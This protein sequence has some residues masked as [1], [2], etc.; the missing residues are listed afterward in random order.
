MTLKFDVS[1]RKWGIF[2]LVQILT[3]SKVGSA[4]RWRRIQWSRD[5]DR[6]LGCYAAHCG[7]SLTT[8][9]ENLSVPLAPLKRGSIDCPETSASNYHHALLNIPEG[10]GY[11]LFHCR[12]LISGIIRHWW[13]AVST[14]TRTELTHY[15]GADKPLAR[16]GRKQVNVSVR[17]AWISFDTLPCRKRNL[18]TARVSVLLKCARPWHVSELVTFLVGLRTYQHPGYI[19]W[20]DFLNTSHPEWIFFFNECLRCEF[21]LK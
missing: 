9:R 12:G 5:T 19:G 15:R 13:N 18:M 16:P 8:F 14:F 10:L 21:S 4:A 11:Y 17:M 7:T 1:D 2:I 3:N 20:S 6:L